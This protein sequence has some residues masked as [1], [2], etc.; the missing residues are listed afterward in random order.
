LTSLYDSDSYEFVVFN[1]GTQV[2][3]LMSDL[4]THSGPLK[5]L[6]DKSRVTQWAKYSEKH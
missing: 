6:S 2:D 5:R 4:E 3:L 1:N